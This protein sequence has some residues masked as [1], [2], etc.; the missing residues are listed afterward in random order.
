VS[1]ATFASA[2]GTA[3]VSMLVSL[4]ACLLADQSQQPRAIKE[5]FVLHHP[6]NVERKQR[7]DEQLR[8]EHIEAE[9]IEVWSVEELAALPRSEFD[10]LYDQFRFLKEGDSEHWCFANKISL[11][12]VSVLLKHFEAIKRIVQRGLEAALVI[13][14]DVILAENFMSQLATSLH[15]LKGKE[16]DLLSIGD[17]NPPMHH[18]EFSAGAER[19]VFRKTWTGGPIYAVSALNVMRSPDSYVLSQHG[20][21]EMHRAFLPQAFPIDNHMNYLLNKLNLSVYWAGKQSFIFLYNIWL[22]TI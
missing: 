15:L 16:W 4:V 17:G 7:L 19:K 10:A 5:V 1:Q 12:H 2:A 9:W 8:R 20:A 18:P 21:S 22:L 11:K 14:D 6:A 13:E 3:K